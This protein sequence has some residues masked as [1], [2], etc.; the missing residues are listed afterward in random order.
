MTLVISVLDRPMTSVIGL[1]STLMTADTGEREAREVYYGKQAHLSPLGHTYEIQARA[2]HPNAIHAITRLVPA[3]EPLAHHCFRLRGLSL[4]GLD[5]AAS[6]PTQLASAHGYLW[7][8]A[9]DLSSRTTAV[10]GP[11]TSLVGA[12]PVLPGL[13]LPIHPRAFHERLLAPTAAAHH[14]CLDRQHQ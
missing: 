13:R 2:D 9:R 14:G 12:G 8:L 4:R 1:S 6:H 7:C 11:H 10:R 3:V 5:D